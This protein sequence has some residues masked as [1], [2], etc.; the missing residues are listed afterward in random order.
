M[1]NAKRIT[2]LSAAILLAAQLFAPF[3]PAA[4]ADDESKQDEQLIAT[5]ETATQSSQEEENEAGI[6]LESN[7]GSSA[8]FYACING[9]WVK[10]GSST[11]LQGPEHLAG[12]ERYY[13]TAEQLEEIYAPFGFVAEKFAGEEYFPHTDDYNR[14]TIWADAPAEGKGKEAKVPVS[15]RKK[16]YVY[17]LPSNKEGTE[18]YFVSSKDITDQQTKDDNE[19]FTVSVVDDIGFVDQELPD[20]QY[21]LTGTD[22]TITLPISADYA[23][24]CVNEETGEEIEVAGIPS[25][26]GNSETYTI[27]S[28]ISSLRFETISTELSFSYNASVMNSL[29]KLGYFEPE[30]Q[31]VVTDAGVEGK[32]LFAEKYADGEYTIRDVDTDITLVEVPS[33]T[34]AGAKFYYRFVGWR[35]WDSDTIL[36]PGTVLTEEEIET[37]EKTNGAIRLKAVW[38]AKAND[39]NQRVFSVNFYIN[40]DCEIRDSMSNGFK[41]EPYEWFSSSVYTTRLLNGDSLPNTGNGTILLLAPP[42]SEDTAYETDT[43]LRNATPDSLPY[44]VQVE[45]FP[46]DE[47]VLEGLRATQDTTDHPV[48]LHGVKV[49]AEDITTDNFTVRWYCLKYSASD[50]WHVDGILVAKVGK[51]VVQKT[52]AGDDAA[53]SEVKSGDYSINVTHQ[54]DDGNEVEDY[55]LS[56]DAESKDGKTGYT[57]YDADTDTYTWVMLAAQGETYTVKEKNYLPSDS[58]TWHTE[59]RAGIMRSGVTAWKDYDTENGISMVAEAYAEDLPFDAYSRVKL[60]NTYVK[61]GMLRIHKVDAYTGDG[62]ANIQFI[63][64]RA[65]GEALTLYRKQGTSEYSTASNATDLGFT[66]A[67]TRNIITTNTNGDVYISL[68]VNTADGLTGRYYL[69]ELTPDGYEAIPKILV[70]VSD[71]GQLDIESTAADG[72]SLDGIVDSS[73]TSTLTIKNTSSH[74]I[75]VVAKKNWSDNALDKLPVTVQLYLNGQLMSGHRAVLDEANNW[76]DAWQDLP[77]YADGKLAKYTIREVAIG[78]TYSD[79]GSFENYVV[80]YAPAKYQKADGETHDTAFWEEDGMTVCADKAILEVTN[81]EAAE[82]MDVTIEKHV[83][84][85]MGDRK[86]SFAFTLSVMQNE[87][88]AQYIFGTTKNSGNTTFELKDFESVKLRIPKGSVLTVEEDEYTDYDVSYTIGDSDKKY[89]RSVQTQI[90]STTTI[91]FYNNKE[92]IPDVGVREDGMNPYMILLTVSG[93]SL[94]AFGMK[95]RKKLRE[96]EDDG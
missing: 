88:D 54:D 65:D 24:K 63:L 42:S 16:S 69:E 40:K 31:Q 92:P 82:Y 35:V 67:M 80:W 89:G 90:D 34:S 43:A 57:Y 26:D 20:T 85:G 8:E 51:L 12:R 64:S 14:N 91:A 70:T 72:T 27:A 71:N 62:M 13:L 15:F 59:T 3:I 4:Y 94:A 1:T 46:S 2:S 68:M 73:N 6:E 47:D 30:R 49:A 50:G 41:Y 87:Q 5:A 28:I 96:G 93:A 74:T 39:V 84:G 21:A 29:M 37:L 11:D 66:E 75:T 45:S 7:D 22:F 56:L 86:K 36:E 76:Q 83:T 77:L 81:N 32:T 58:D 23:W 10:V 78:D 53:I 79:S 19:F 60:E 48:M 17:Y 9:D 44:G 33:N 61:A 52:F 55:I 38:T 95:H 25:E 18:S